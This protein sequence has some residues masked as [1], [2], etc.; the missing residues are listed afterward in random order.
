MSSRPVT[1][2]ISRGENK[3][4]TNFIRSSG[5]HDKKIKTVMIVGGGLITYY[6]SKMLIDHDFEVK[7]I[8]INEDRC[9]KF[10]E[11]IP[12]ALLICG[13]GTERELL[14]AEGI[15]NVD[16]F[17]ALTDMDEEKPDHVHVRK[18]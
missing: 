18:V 11:D 10:C 7:I 13:N 8:E 1:I 4:I 6:L 12:Q 2:S 3:C 14:D 15:S 17:V 5:Y 9:E 16:A